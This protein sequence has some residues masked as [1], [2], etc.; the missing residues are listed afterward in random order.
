MKSQNEYDVLLKKIVALAELKKMSDAGKYYRIGGL[1]KQ[2]SKEV[3][4]GDSIIEKLSKDLQRKYAKG[5]SIANLSNMQ[6][7]YQKYRNAPTL[8]KYAEKLEWN[9]NITLLSIH[10]LK[11]TEYYLK[12]ASEE[13]MSN[14][15]LKERIEKDAYYEYINTVE[16]KNYKIEIEKVSIK[17]YKSLVNIEIV[18][19]SR[20]SVFA[21]ANSSG[22]S[23]ILEAIEFLFHSMKINGKEVFNVFGGEDGVLNYNEQLKKNKNLFINIEFLDRTNFTVKY[24]G[25]DF[26]NDFSVSTKLNDRFYN[27]FTRLFIEKSKRSESKL[28]PSNK[29]WFDASNLSAILKNILMDLNK[30]EEMIEWLSLFIPGLS[31]ITVE[32]DKLNGKEDLF[33]FENN[34]KK[35]FTGN[36]ISD[37]TYNIIALLTLIYQKDSPQF[38]CIEEPENGLNPKVLKEIVK[39]FRKICKEEGHYIWISTHSQ[40]IVSELTPDELILVDKHDGKTQIKQF[41]GQKFDNIPMDEAWLNNILDGGL[42]W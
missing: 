35:P 20:F 19:P 7:F 13:K 11:E 41:Q 33:I 2:N 37:G 39:L 16:N 8:Y 15:I 18:G 17:N 14:S 38:L 3:G 29:L 9:K 5:F 30:K 24:D 28:K 26:Q 42:P 10:D 27:A 22:K 4:R 36:L 21:G 31:N 32:S 6:Q 23:N 34:T 1:I 12:A 25:K 40:T